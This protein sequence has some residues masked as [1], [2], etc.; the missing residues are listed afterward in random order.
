[1][2]GYT[3]D[4]GGKDIPREKVYYKVEIRDIDDEMASVR[5]DSFGYLDYLHL[6]KD[7]GQWLIINVLYKRTP[8]D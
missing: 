7:D 4:G 1:M 5:V 2:V 6:V 8:V 3:K